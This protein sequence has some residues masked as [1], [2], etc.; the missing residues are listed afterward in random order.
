MCILIFL[1]EKSTEALGRQGV[2]G[3]LR[4][5]KQMETQINFRDGKMEPFCFGWNVL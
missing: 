4:F 5:Y 2:G 3:M 1:L